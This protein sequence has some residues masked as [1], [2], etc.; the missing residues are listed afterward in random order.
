MPG[1]ATLVAAIRELLAESP[2]HG[3]GYRKSGRDCASLAF[4]PPSAASYA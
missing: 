2:L 4:A 1:E 3:E